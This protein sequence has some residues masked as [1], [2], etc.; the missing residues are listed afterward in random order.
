MLGEKKLI[1]IVLS[2]FLS[3]PGMGYAATIYAS[4]CSRSHV[5]TAID[6]S[7]TGD[8][9]VIPSGSCTWTSGVSIPSSKKL[10]IIGAGIGSTVITWN[11]DN[12]VFALN[13][14]G[15]RLSRMTI[16]GQV[17][18]SGGNGWRIDHVSFVNAASNSGRGIW[19]IPTSTGE[20]TAA[21]GLVDNCTFNRRRIMVNGVYSSSLYN[22]SK[23]WDDPLDLGTINK[24]VY[25]EDN[26]FRHVEV[27]NA[28]DAQNAGA[29]VFRFNTVYDTYVEL[30]GMAETM[31]R[32]SRKMELYGNDFIREAVSGWYQIAR[33]NSGTGVVFDNTY[34]GSESAVGTAAFLLNEI[35]TATN[36]GTDGAGLCNGS[37][38]FDGNTAGQ[39]GWPCRDQIGTSTDSWLWTSGNPYPPQSLAPYYEWNN[40]QNG[41]N[42]T[43]S[44]LSGS[45]VHIK[46]NRDFY[47]E[48]GSFDGTSGVGRGTIGSRPTT[49]TTGVAYW[50]TDEGEWNS[51]HDGPDGRL[52]KCTATNTWTLYYTPY[53]YP[54][55]LRGEGG[56]I[57]I[58]G[59]GAPDI[60]TPRGLRIF[61]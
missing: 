18:V 54:H 28:V 58:G 15:S 51:T 25:I 22:V 56:G 44:I 24:T 36:T 34:T 5:Q 20:G 47:S 21:P 2:G 10:S 4:S 19:I 27:H 40:T 12:T 23:V 41:R 26:T 1:A 3:L 49:C 43:F 13:E 61:N 52:Y 32:G 45:E 31:H 39:N 48:T 17:T 9:V 37:S 38:P 8:T 7:T 33:I 11:R 42:M 35:R 60:Q 57:K 29:Y 6:S 55:P 53:T 50:A 59:G 14:S 30:H 16:D 46:A